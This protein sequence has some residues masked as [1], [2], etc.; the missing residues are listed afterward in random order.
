MSWWSSS[1][2]AIH[3]ARST[4]NGR[5]SIGAVIAIIAVE[6]I[7]RRASSRRRI[8]PVRLTGAITPDRHVP[9]SP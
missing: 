7:R 3:R 9:P 5:R 2:E 4:E 8:A 6:I 1:V